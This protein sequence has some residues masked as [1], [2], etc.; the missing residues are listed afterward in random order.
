MKSIVTRLAIVS[1]LLLL[2]INWNEANAQW[3]KKPTQEQ[4]EQYPG[5][6][7]ETFESPAMKTTVSYSVVLPPSYKEGSK[8][9]PVVYW[10]H[11]GHKNES[12]DLFTSKTWQTLFKENKIQEVILVYPN[13][14]TS[15]YMDHADGKVMVETMI[16]R[17]LIPRIDERFRSI[18]SR[19]GRAAHGSSMG[20]SGSL[21][22][23]IKYPE[24]FCSAVA[25]GGG[26]TDL[27][28]TKDKYVLGILE[29]NL[30][31]K[32]ELVRQ[33]N[34]YHFLKKN[35]DT[36]RNKGTKIVLVTGDKDRWMESARTFQAALRA[37]DIPCRLVPVPGAGHDLPKTFGA[38]GEASAIFQ[39]EMFKK[40]SQQ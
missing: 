25:Y 9:Y 38:Q 22:F 1:A 34:T 35:A 11:G 16:I 33:N 31:S 36:L 39:D 28:N 12:A 2:A 15:G 19:E 21:K 3:V 14:F 37:E 20:A 7:H 26:A 18:A 5:L 27:E 10:L 40:L 8:R 29:K 32:P 4:F 23:A 17:E 30:Q 6:V 24:M 13:G